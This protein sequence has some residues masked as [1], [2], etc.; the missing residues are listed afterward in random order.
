LETLYYH[1]LSGKTLRT[2][3]ADAAQRAS[4]AH[5]RLAV[6]HGRIADYWQGLVAPPVNDTHPGHNAHVDAMH[7]HKGRATRHASHRHD[8]LKHNLNT[9]PDEILPAL[10]QRYELSEQ[11]ATAGLMHL[12]ASDAFEEAHRHAMRECGPF[13]PAN[14]PSSPSF[15]EPHPC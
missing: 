1:T 9:H 12:E 10:K 14:D 6:A 5:G 4:D 8:V 15:V 3:V 11:H 13:V 7:L 2:Q